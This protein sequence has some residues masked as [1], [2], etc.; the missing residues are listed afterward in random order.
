[1]ISD[2]FCRV[3][4]P[5][6]TLLG[7]GAAAGAVVSCA[8]QCRRRSADLFER[9]P[10]H[11]RFAD[12]RL[13]RKLACGSR[14]GRKNPEKTLMIHKPHLNVRRWSG[15]TPTCRY[16]RLTSRYKHSTAAPRSISLQQERGAQSV[17]P[18]HTQASRAAAAR[19][20]RC[21]LAVGAPPHGDAAAVRAGGPRI[22]H[23]QPAAPGT[24]GQ[25]CF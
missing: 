14:Q 18:W 25:S 16:N 7:V 6:V 12:E 22:D 13:A 24:Q 19:V 3:T 11:W 4:V 17:S 1:M 8:D 5:C 10:N 2:K 9:L 23:V 20:Q 21:W 15:P